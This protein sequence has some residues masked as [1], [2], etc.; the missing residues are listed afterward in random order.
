V[1]EKN[2]FK[3]LD[4]NLVTIS[5]KGE[6]PGSG[7]GTARLISV[8]YRTGNGCITE[9]LHGSSSFLISNLQSKGNASCGVEFEYEIVGGLRQASV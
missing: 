5:E 2:L 3:N 6:I 1:L 8:L 7:S 4:F 9:E